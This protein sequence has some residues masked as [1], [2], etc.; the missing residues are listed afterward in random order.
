MDKRDQLKLIIQEALNDNEHESQVENL[1]L[2]SLLEEREPTPEE[3]R[4]LALKEKENATRQQRD[5][6]AKELE[7]IRK[8]TLGKT[9]EVSQRKLNA[10]RKQA[11]QAS[12]NL[13]DQKKKIKYGT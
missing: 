10:K 13:G 5:D 4:F 9:D 3:K 1:V 11:N 8:E 2:Q 6:K 12:R 7:E